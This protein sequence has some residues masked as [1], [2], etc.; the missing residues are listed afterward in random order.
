MASHMR[1]DAPSPQ[2]TGRTNAYTQQQ[3]TYV[4]HPVGY[5]SYGTPQPRK[6]KHGCLIFFVVMLLLTLVAGGVFGFLFYSSAMTVRAEANEVI[7]SVRTLKAQ[8]K[9]ADFE[10]AAATAE[11]MAS[12]ASV[13]HAQT[14]E[15]IWTVARFI[16]FVGADV[17]RICVIAEVADELCA[18][19]IVPLVSTVAE[20]PLSSLLVDGAINVDALNGL[21]NAVNDAGP[22]IQNAAQRL[23]DLGDPLLPQIAGPLNKVR[24]QLDEASEMLDAVQP[25]LSR[26]PELLGVGGNTRHYLIVAQSNAEI[27]ATGGFAGSWGILEV[28]DGHLDLQDFQSMQRLTWPEE[29]QRPAMTDE[30]VNLFGAAMVTTPTNVNMTP[31]YP[32]AAELMQWYWAFVHDGQQVDAVISIDPVFLQECLALTDGITASN[33]WRVDG[34][35]A[36]SVLLNQVY[37]EIPVENQDDF[38]AE[39]AGAAFKQ[40]LGGLGKA[41][42]TNLIDLVKSAAES[43]RLL[44]WFPDEDLESLVVTL[45]LDGGLGTDPANPELGV[46]VNDDSWS[47]IS[48]YMD[49]RTTVTGSEQN[50]D[51]TT[52]Y[53]CQTV[54][55]NM[56]DPTLQWVAPGYIQGSSP[57]RRN[58]CDMVTHLLLVAPAGGTVENVNC[59]TSVASGHYHSLNGLPVWTGMVNTN[60]GEQTVFTYDVT[61][62]VGAAELTIRQTPTG[63]TIG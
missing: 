10:G 63:Q 8:V 58:P 46:Y 11:E 29:S 22:I 13:M 20:T 17:N 31:H 37:W 25:I 44:V 26:M 12:T 21:V 14:Q 40:F 3:S 35:N 47:K 53:H 34:T 54:I 49:L 57:A 62:A 61:V 19:G 15:P 30:E 41:G 6:K 27:R 28:T 18:E 60:M 9:E 16:P 33:G 32:R 59:S 39:V 48:W 45:G 38:F 51:G 36:A 43:H 23:D 52:T 4:Q 24:A 7:E 2:R 1:Q 5:Q 55:R 56:F 50:A 42:M